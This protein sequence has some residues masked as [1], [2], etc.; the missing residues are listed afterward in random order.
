[1]S[2]KNSKTVR[3]QV[4]ENQTFDR[5]S[6]LKLA[7]VAGDGLGGGF[8]TG[9]LST[10]FTTPAQAA[11]TVVDDFSNSN[12]SDRYVFDQRNATTGVTTISS[13]VTSEADA[14][15]L[16][17]EGDG[18]TVMHAFNADEDTDLN[19]YPEPG[20]TFSCWVRG[21]N[22]TEIM[23]FSYGAQDA[24]NKYYV[25]FNLDSAHLGLFKYVN[26][27]GRSL[28]GDWSNSTIQNNTSWFKVEIQWTT[29]HQHTVTLYQNGSEVT[30]FSYTE[31]SD[32][33]QFTA[34]GVGFSGHLNSGETAQ[35]DYSTTT[36]DGDGG[37]G[38]DN[39]SV[40]KQSNI[41]NFEVAAKEL[42]AYRFD[43]GESGAEII[44]DEE[45]SEKDSFGPTYSGTRAL[46][47]S[48]ST[49]TEMISLPGD[50]LES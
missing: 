16:Q 9:A 38:S 44:A 31:D 10:Q 19:A 43:R 40:Y 30:S 11:T 24:N 41:D 29:D 15:V 37:G 28:S 46:K 6:Y 7:S 2:E 8:G 23:N 18:S 32:D 48:D 42:D 34:N 33:P 27:S 36:E 49:A 21:L 39:G 3:E 35:F 14:N 4:A 17:M 20:D 45:Q 50:G 25:Q 5:R 22:G 47:I 1:M 12:L 26:G 13:S